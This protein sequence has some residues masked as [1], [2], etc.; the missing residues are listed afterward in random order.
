MSSVLRSKPS[1]KEILRTL[2][3]RLGDYESDFCEVERDR[4]QY[5]LSLHIAYCV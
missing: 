4:E 1:T 2:D 3:A 5:E